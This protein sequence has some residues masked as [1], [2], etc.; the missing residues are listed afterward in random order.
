MRATVIYGAR[1]IRL[2]EVADP[3]LRT[4]GDAI[5]RVVVASCVCGS[6][7]WPYRGVTETAEPNR[8]GQEF[9]GVVEAVGVRVSRMAVG[10]FVI[11]P[12]HHS[13]TTCVN[14]PIGVSPSCLHGG[15]VG[16]CRPNGRVRRR[17]PRGVR[18]SF[19]R[20]WKPGGDP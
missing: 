14:C 3:V 17:R 10:D 7:L 1:N 11:P 16:Q 12:S 5:V 20:R 13:N 4:R 2:E 9:V 8:I 19:P 15:L 6:D 18:E